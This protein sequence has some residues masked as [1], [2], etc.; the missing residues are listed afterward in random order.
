MRTFA[1]LLALTLLALTP[2]RTEAQIGADWFQSVE[3]TDKGI[4]NPAVGGHVI[5]QAEDISFGVSATWVP[6]FLNDDGGSFA[7][8]FD[9]EIEHEDVVVSFGTRGF[10][11]ETDDDGNTVKRADSASTRL[12]DIDNVSVG[13]RLPFGGDSSKYVQP[14]ISYDFDGG[15]GFSFGVRISS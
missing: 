9:Y 1:T 6:T 10:G 8:T 5:Y 14:R 3:V 12:G 4:S 2:E 15:D 13:L 7:A 11:G